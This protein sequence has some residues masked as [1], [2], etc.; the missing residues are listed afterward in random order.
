MQDDGEFGQTTLCVREPRSSQD[1]KRMCETHSMNSLGLSR[2]SRFYNTKFSGFPH[3]MES[4]YAHLADAVSVCWRHR[5]LVQ[6]LGRSQPHRTWWPWHT[7]DKSDKTYLVDWRNSLYKRL[8]HSQIHCFHIQWFFSQRYHQ[9][10]RIAKVEML[11]SASLDTMQLPYL[12]C[13]PLLYWW[14][15]LNFCVIEPLLAH[16]DCVF[17]GRDYAFLWHKYLSTT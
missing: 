17:E 13:L 3:N 8:K 1:S 15:G 5:S 9:M 7:I 10:G 11:L 6:L 2:K 12:H 4:P 14:G 16:L